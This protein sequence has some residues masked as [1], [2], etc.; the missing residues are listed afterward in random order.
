MRGL[1]ALAAAAAE[2]ASLVGVDSVGFQDLCAGDLVQVPAARQHRCL[3]GL[4]ALAAHLCGGQ[5][6]G[7]EVHD[8]VGRQAALHDVRAQA[9]WGNNLHVCFKL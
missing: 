3:S 5:L 7:A 4:L 9:L 8:L 2:L 1:R 6:G